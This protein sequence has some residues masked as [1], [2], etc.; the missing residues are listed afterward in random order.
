MLLHRTNPDHPINSPLY[1]LFTD[2]SVL[3]G[4]G[5]AGIGWIL[6]TDD[7]VEVKMGHGTYADCDT[8]QA[9]ALAMVEGLKAARDVGAQ[10]LV[11]HT[12]NQM[13]ARC[14]TGELSRPPPAYKPSIE[15]VRQYTKPLYDCRVRWIPRHLNEAAD[16]LAKRA[17]VSL[18]NQYAILA[19]I[20]GAT[21]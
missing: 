19:Q 13:L 20:K 15:T 16:G 9:E 2:A 3:G 14:L 1:F 17:L 5:P 21:A 11:L 4:D 10:R 6:E 18:K 12:D 8:I 7:G